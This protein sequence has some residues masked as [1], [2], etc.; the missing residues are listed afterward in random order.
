MRWPSRTKRDLLDNRPEQNKTLTLTKDMTVAVGRL[1]LTAYQ[2]VKVQP[3]QYN[4]L[5]ARLKACVILV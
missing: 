3:A 2:F 1:V 5:G 4:Y